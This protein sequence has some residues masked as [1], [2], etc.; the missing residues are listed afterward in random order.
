MFY[1]SEMSTVRYMM[2]NIFMSFVVSFAFGR[3]EELIFSKVL[4]M[5]F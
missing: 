2:L 1:G 3:P 5:N 4:F